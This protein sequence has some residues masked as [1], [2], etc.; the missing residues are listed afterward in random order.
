V[1]KDSAAPPKATKPKAEASKAAATPTSKSETQTKQAATQ[2]AR[3]YY[4]CIIQFHSHYRLV[5]PATRLLMQSYGLSMDKVSA[6]GPRGSL[7]KSCV[8]SLRLVYDNIVYLK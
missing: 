6:S 8:Y 3:Y 5:G 2:P 4:K 1:P 7:M